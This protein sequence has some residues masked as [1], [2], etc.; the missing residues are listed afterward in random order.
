[1]ANKKIFLSYKR[2]EP[3]TEIAEL[4][5][6]RI[7]VNLEGDTYGFSE[8]FFD[9]HSI[10]AGA[11]WNEEIDQALAETTHFVAL[12]SD[13]YWLSKQCQRELQDAVALYE[14]KGSPK[15]LFV[16]TEK[17]D[18]NALSIATNSKTAALKTPFPKVKNVGQI[19]FLGPYDQAGRLVKLKC[20]DITALKD[21]LFDLTQD[22]KKLK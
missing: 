19:N 22:I 1:M 9:Q 8:T 10:D 4:L 20:N 14:Q 21:Q 16:L 6:K 13:D 12:L 7:Q 2:G 15:L 18:P 3:T 17:M 5:F 11:D